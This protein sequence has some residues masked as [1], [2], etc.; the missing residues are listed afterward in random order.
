MVAR[1]GW[2]LPREKRV[3]QQ[4]NADGCPGV[5]TLY[6]EQ[7]QPDSQRKRNSEPLRPRENARNHCHP[8]G[9]EDFQSVAGARYDARELKDCERHM[10]RALGLKVPPSSHPSGG[11]GTRP[12]QK[13]HTKDKR[14][15]VLLETTMPKLRSLTTPHTVSDDNIA[16]SAAG[17]HSSREHKPRTRYEYHHRPHLPPPAFHPK[18]L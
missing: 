2:P 15:P 6:D 11:S 13:P 1:R 12:H 5:T 18:P 17:H 8:H 3:C 9:Y 10:A 7:T 14:Q 4:V 16:N